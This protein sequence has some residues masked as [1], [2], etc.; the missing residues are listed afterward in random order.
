MDNVIATR[1]YRKYTIKENLDSYVCRKRLQEK[2]I[3]ELIT[4]GC[5]LIAGIEYLDR[6]NT[7]AT[8]IRIY[9]SGKEFKLPNNWC[10]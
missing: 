8:N 3:N 1:K 9:Y 5:K 10:D 6:Y 7:A 4:G 2:E